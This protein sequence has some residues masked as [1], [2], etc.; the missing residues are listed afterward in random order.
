M[1]RR[2]TT[3]ATKTTQIAGFHLP[4]FWSNRYGMGSQKLHFR[5]VSRWCWC[6]RSRNHML[7]TTAPEE[8]PSTMPYLPL[9]SSNLPYPFLHP[10]SELRTALHTS[11]RIQKPSDLTSLIFTPTLSVLPFHNPLPSS[12]IVGGVPLFLSEANFSS[13][14]LAFSP[15]FDFLRYFFSYNPSFLC[16]FTN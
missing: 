12:A 1:V 15:P 10:P 4:S 13:Y 8:P 16:L 7:R 6:S 5:K 11:R 9:F 2:L 3:T 14:I